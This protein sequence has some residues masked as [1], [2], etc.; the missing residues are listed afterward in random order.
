MPVFAVLVVW[1]LQVSSIIAIEK[2]N[3]KPT[4]RTTTELKH[5]FLFLAASLVNFTNAVPSF[6]KMEEMINFLS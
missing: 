3:Q 5:T 4:I 2:I 1:F 6:S